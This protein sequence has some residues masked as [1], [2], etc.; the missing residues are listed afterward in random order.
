MVLL[1]RSASEAEESLSHADQRAA[2]PN[3][4]GMLRLRFTTAQHDKEKNVLPFVSGIPTCRT[5][6]SHGHSEAQRQRS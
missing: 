5:C 1:K 2:D 6:H 4:L 3:G